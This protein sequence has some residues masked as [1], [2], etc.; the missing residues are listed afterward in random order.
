[1]NIIVFD[2]HPTRDNLLPLTYT[3]PVGDL[4]IGV[5]TIAEKWQQLI[6]GEYSWQ[7]E[8]YLSELYHVAGHVQRVGSGMA[9]V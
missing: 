1:M 6:P 8:P 7:T 4:R 2:P 9:R 3:R 5:T